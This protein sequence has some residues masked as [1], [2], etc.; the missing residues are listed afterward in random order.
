M[1]ILQIVANL[2]PSTPSTDSSITSIIAGVTGSI[3]IAISAICSR[4]RIF[5][6]FYTSAKVNQFTE[7][8]DCIIRTL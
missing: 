2:A 5:A 6:L 8:I 1:W 3:G 7:R 4:A